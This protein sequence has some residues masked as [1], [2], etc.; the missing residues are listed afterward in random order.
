MRKRA[1]AA[2]K[3]VMTENE[4]EKVVVAI[5][6]GIANRVTEAK[7]ELIVIGM[8]DESEVTVADP[9]IEIVDDAGHREVA[10]VG[11]A[12]VGVGIAAVEGK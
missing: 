2:K 10:V 6:V 8:E 1:R 5:A 12:G 11:T 9:L 3:I 7:I 4:T